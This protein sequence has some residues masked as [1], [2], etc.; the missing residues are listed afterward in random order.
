MLKDNQQSRDWFKLLPREKKFIFIFIN[1][2]INILSLWCML[3][4]ITKTYNQKLVGLS[5]T[6]KSIVVYKSIIL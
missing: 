4:Y 6:E 5:N 1:C 2:K 3:T